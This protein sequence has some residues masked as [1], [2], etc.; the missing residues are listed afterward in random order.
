MQT[1]LF[2]LLGQCA[3]MLHF[4]QTPSSSF[5]RSLLY[6]PVPLQSERVVVIIHK[7]Q[8]S[9]NSTSLREPKDGSLS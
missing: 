6:V 9:F 5:E 4:V 3:V 1:N 7:Q 2:V 8:T